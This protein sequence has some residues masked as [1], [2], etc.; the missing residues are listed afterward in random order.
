[1]PHDKRRFA[2][3][4]G[5]YTC[6]CCG[7]RTRAVDQDAANCR[8]CVQCFD[9][10][11]WENGHSDNGHDQQPDTSCPVCIYFG[12][13]PDTGFDFSGYS[14]KILGQRKVYD[15]RHTID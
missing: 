13:V 7:K 12:L 8:L 5:C 4:S 3:G 14:T 11:G 10:T 6:Q 1:M 9:W 15:D 2:K